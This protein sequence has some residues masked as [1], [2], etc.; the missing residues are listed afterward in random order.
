MTPTLLV[1]A[2]LVL[3]IVGIAVAAI[4]TAPALDAAGVAIG[5]IGAV[6]LVSAAFLA[7]GLSEDR[8]RRKHGP[9]N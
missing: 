4:G 9:G 1:R 5:G 8:D 6:L 3:L 2:G 7:V